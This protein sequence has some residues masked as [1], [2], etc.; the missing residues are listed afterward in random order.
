VFLFKTS[1]CALF[2]Y[3]FFF[4]EV[5]SYKVFNEA[6]LTQGYVIFPISPLGFLGRYQR[7][8]SFLKLFEFMIGDQYL[9]YSS[10]FPQGFGGIFYFINKRRIRSR[11]SVTN[12][13]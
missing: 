9:Y 5:F 11:G 13:F 1:H 8:R 7:H 2:F 12:K 4:F 3:E 6:M 10:F